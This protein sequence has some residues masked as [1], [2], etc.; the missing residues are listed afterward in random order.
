MQEKHNRQLQTINAYL[1]EHGEEQCDAYDNV[2][3]KAL[4]IWTGVT[5]IACSTDFSHAVLWLYVQSAS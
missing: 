4:S 5:I 1:L 2:R 3:K